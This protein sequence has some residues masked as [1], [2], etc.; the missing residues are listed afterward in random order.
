[1]QPTIPVAIAAAL[2]IG[3]EML[4]RGL[5]DDQ[6]KT[7]QN[8]LIAAFALVIVA[9]GCAWLA[10]NFTGNLQ[11][12]ILIIIAYIA[13]LMRGS[14]AMLYQF[15]DLAAS[16]LAP[17]LAPVIPIPRRASAAQNKPPDNTPHG[18]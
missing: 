2:P 17:K 13:L 5:T 1:M 3:G 11:A 15:F 7:W 8:A 16:P 12:S 6:L 14:L 18:G 4:A 10:G 9:I